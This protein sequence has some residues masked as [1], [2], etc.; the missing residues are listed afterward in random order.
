M[1]LIDDFEEVTQK[2]IKASKE[3]DELERT[4]TLEKAKIM[5]V[6]HGQYTNQDARETAA[7]LQME[8][9]QAKLLNDLYRARGEVREYRLV[10]D[11]IWERL[12]DRRANSL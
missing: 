4:F 11:V 3:L 9:E 6:V 7:T 10:R 1:K 5:S 8:E 12:K 2:L